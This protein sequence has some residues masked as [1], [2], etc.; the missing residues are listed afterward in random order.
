MR[1]DIGAEGM[2]SDRS[3]EIRFAAPRPGS[4]S[5]EFVAK[6]RRYG[7]SARLLRLLHQDISD[8]ETIAVPDADE[9]HVEAEVTDRPGQDPV[10]ETLT[11]D[12]A[13]AW[14]VLGD[15]HPGALASM[16][17][18][19]VSLRD[20]G[21]LAAVRQMCEQ[22]LAACRRVLGEEH[23]NTLEAMNNLALVLGASG[24]LAAARELSEQVLAVRRRVLGAEHP[25]TLTS[26]NN[27]ATV[28]ESLG[29]TDAAQELTEQLLAV[30]RRTLDPAHPDTVASMNRFATALRSLADLTAARRSQD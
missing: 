9:H 19:V 7:A 3:H 30:R 15:E 6:I 21:E 20:R 23:P 4:V 2:P 22:V 14:R 16:G 5:P 8:A 26:M 11:S 13:V 17:D 1:S 12:D 27:L 24:E 18:L 29:E 28:L 10:A 25:D